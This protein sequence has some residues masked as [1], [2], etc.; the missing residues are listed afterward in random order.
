MNAE[1][2]RCPAVTLYAFETKSLTEPM[3]KPRAIRPQ[4]SFCHPF[5]SAEVT[6]S[7]QTRAIFYVGE[8]LSS[9][10]CTAGALSHRVISPTH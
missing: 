5:H 10:V 1:P 9:H 7:A 6:G 2:R 3:A 8:N 4:Q